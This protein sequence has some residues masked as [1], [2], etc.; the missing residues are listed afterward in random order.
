MLAISYKDTGIG[1]HHLYKLL[2]SWHYY[3]TMAEIIMAE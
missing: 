2:D 1:S 3:T